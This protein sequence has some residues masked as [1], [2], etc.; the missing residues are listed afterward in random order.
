[1]YGG[2]PMERRELSSSG[3]TFADGMRAG[4]P[5]AAGY[6]PIAVAFGLLAK[7]AGIPNHIAILMSLAV[8]AGASQFIGAN[9][10]AAGVTPWEIVLTTFIINLRHML[11]SASLSGRIEKNA[12]GAL[13][14]AL[15]FGITDETFSVASFRKE[16]ALSPQFILGLN[17]LAFAS[18]N[19]GTW[20]GIFLAR[21]LPDLVRDSMGIALYAM[22][23]GLLVPSLKTSRPVLAVFLL[24]V[25]IHSVLYWSPLIPG[26]S[27]GWGIIITTLA[28]AAAGAAIFPGGVTV[29]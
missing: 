25:A 7:S 24:A 27:M 22:F 12:P 23:I 6:I 11:M 2:V 10:M 1:M 14:P 9:M 29:D 4:I 26:L 21:G 3:L 17:L 20:A 15:A 28:A 5:I 16:L 18:W 13:L 19:A 8:F